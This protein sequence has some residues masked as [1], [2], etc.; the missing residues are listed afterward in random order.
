MDEILKRQED[1][2]EKMV[3]GTITPEEK[4]EWSKTQESP[5][6]KKR[7]EEREKVSNDVFSNIDNKE[8]AP[9]D[10]GPPS[11][12]GEGEGGGGGE[13]GGEGERAQQEDIQSVLYPNMNL[14]TQRDKDG[15]LKYGDV[16]RVQNEER[17]GSA[18]GFKAQSPNFNNP[19]R[20]DN[21]Q[22]SGV[23]VAENATVPNIDGLLDEDGKPRAATDVDIANRGRIL[24]QNAALDKRRQDL[25]K[26]MA[27]SE[28]IK[29]GLAGRGSRVQTEGTVGHGGKTYGN[30][31]HMS[32]EEILGHNSELR[33]QARI[34]NNNRKTNNKFDDF[35][36]NT[37]LNT[38]VGD[39]VNQRIEEAGEDGRLAGRNF[40]DI[41][42]NDPMLALQLRDQFKNR[43]ASDAVRRQERLNPKYTEQDV[44]QYKDDN[45]FTTINDGSGNRSVNKEQ[46]AA[47]RDQ[48]GVEMTGANGGISRQQRDSNGILLGPD[49]QPHGQ[50]PFGN[51]Y[52]GPEMNRQADKRRQQEAPATPTNGLSP[53]PTTDRSMS[54][55]DS[56]PQQDQ[57]GVINSFRGH[58]G[59]APIGGQ[60][61]IPQQNIGMQQDQRSQQP[62]QQK[63]PVSLDNLDG[64]LAQN[65]QLSK[66]K[67]AEEEEEERR[68]RMNQQNPVL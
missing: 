53:T 26:N 25:S 52:N 27:T 22:M 34:A 38:A 41:L 66:T 46:G 1:L 23:D 64:L 45:G 16:Q 61:Q 7:F 60:P 21:G 68:K 39:W 36:K 43:S 56:L 5:E 65:P 8:T 54:Q 2:F 32:P 63:G 20:I 47:F 28:M 33:H 19:Y 10:S 49:G 55:F 18:P 14:A 13:R 50:N 59:E 4:E 3:N 11:F 44:Q 6:F 67:T 42:K 12:D 57:I 58:R 17:Y 9:T 48:V 37:N 35:R 24:E 31:R 29:G 30:D 40:N 15:N 62:G 51:L